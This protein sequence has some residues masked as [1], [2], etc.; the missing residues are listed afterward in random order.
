MKQ[1]IY[2]EMPEKDYRK[3]PA[4]NYSSLADF[5]ISQDH[6][7]LEKTGKS[8]FEFG[9][10]FELLIED[11][12][13]NTSKF[14]ERFFLA[15]VEGEMY[16]DLAGWINNKEDLE[17]KYKWN[18]PKKDGSVVL[19][20][21]HRNRHAWLDECLKNPGM[22]PMGT[23]QMEMLGKM[24]D[25]FML[26]RPLE[27]I[28]VE[29]TLEEIL[30]VAQFQVPIIWY[31]GK[32]RKKILVDCMVDTPKA[33]YVFDIKTAA[34]ERKFRSSLSERYWVQEVH[35]TAG[36]GH[37]HP[38]KDII[39]RFLVAPKD[40]PWVAFPA[41]TDPGSIDLCWAR[42]ADLCERYQEWVDDG[43]PA[44]GWKELET[45]KVWFN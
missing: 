13:K 43:R 37:V 36:T 12:A 30:P 2:L 19:S 40:E 41:I 26:M 10:A 4:L 25:N 38:G 1:G 17:S 34:T 16:K 44:K 35:Y 28:G 6:A 5:N 42:Y 32:M 24:V 29:E 8:Y 31:H 21:T 22:M 15:D 39:W 14:A 23:D 27:D 9:N 3:L 11:R 33:V 45:V 7:L 18:K 20:G